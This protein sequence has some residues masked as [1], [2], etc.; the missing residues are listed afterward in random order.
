MALY[1]TQAILHTTDGLP[2]NFATNSWHCD[3]DDLTALQLFHDELEDFYTQIGTN[4]SSLIDDATS[5]P[6]E[7][8]SYQLSDPE[9]R[10][11]VLKTNFS[12]P[13]VGTSALPAEVAVCCSFQAAQV[14]GLPQARRRN[15][16]YVGPMSQI[17]TDSAGRVASNCQAAIRNRG[18]ALKSASDAASTWTWAIY[19][20]TDGTGADVDNG[21]VD[22]EFDT[23]RRRGRQATDRA[24]F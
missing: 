17:A 21:W 24:T 11:V 6:H 1:V 8:K 23:Q 7:L 9:P 14:S 16:V 22:N 10:A 13:G 19:S 5:D 2:E 18:S 15:R 12:L 20:P 4:M 3:A